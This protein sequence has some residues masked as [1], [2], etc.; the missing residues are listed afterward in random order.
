MTR[1]HIEL[2]VFESGERYP[3]LIDQFGIPHPYV[4]LW[5]TSRLRATGKTESTIINKLSH[6]KKLLTWMD[7]EDKDLFVRFRSGEFLTATEIENLS[8]FLS[9]NVR[10]SN[11]KKVSNRNK[12]IRLGKAVPAYTEQTPS[13]GSSHRHNCITSVTEYVTFL[14]NLAT[15]FTATPESN[16]QIARMEK[17]LKSSRPRAKGVEQNLNRSLSVPS[18]LVREFMAIAHHENE[19]NPFKS[20]DVRFRNHLMFLILESLGIRRGELLS[21]KMTNLILHGAEKSVLITRSHDDPIDPRRKQPVTKTRERKL[22][23]SSHLAEA[24]N[25][26]I[27]EYRSKIPQARKHPYLFVSHKKGKSHG[28]PISSSNFDNTILPALKAVDVKFSAI[29]P[30]LFRH[31]WNE[32]FSQT[33]DERNASCGKDNQISPETEAKM[34]KHQLGHS[35]EESGR[36]YNQRHITRKANEVSLK[37]QEELQ[38]NKSEKIHD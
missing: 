28:Q 9:I 6:V 1:F 29:Y 34:R 2:L 4:T 14:A 30:H 8:R 35:Y 21:L 17:L 36:V 37:E 19:S 27:T 10:K 23:I 5:V 12:V 11:T 20:E 24:I 26:Y 33:I 3:I 16:R 18:S 32:R 25:T 22:A 38:R 13:N 31:D 15:Q 7:K